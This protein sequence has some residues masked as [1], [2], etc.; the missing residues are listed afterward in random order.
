MSWMFLL[1]LFGMLV[2]YP[3]YFYVLREFKVRLVRDHPEIWNGRAHGA[4][5]PSLQTAYHALRAVRDGRLDGVDLTEEVKSSHRLATRL[6]YAGLLFFLVLLF[7]GLYSSVFQRS[8][9]V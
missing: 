1:A 9:V 7:F 8:G 5:S 2:T 3:A 6:L 4:L